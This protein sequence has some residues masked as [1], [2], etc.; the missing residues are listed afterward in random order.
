MTKSQKILGKG[1]SNRKSGNGMGGEWGGGKVSVLQKVFHLVSFQCF[2]NCRRLCG[3]EGE[4]V[5]GGCV[6]PSFK[7]DLKRSVL[8][9]W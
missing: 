4:G 5:G 8:R 1:G 7:F 3:E 2:Q 9:L 6:G